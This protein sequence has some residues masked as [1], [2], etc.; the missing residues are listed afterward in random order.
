MLTADQIYN[1]FDFKL[2][3]KILFGASAAVFLFILFDQATLFLS[4]A[5]FAKKT[6]P[7]NVV[8]L[9]FLDEKTIL[10][11]YL[12]Q[13]NDPGLF[14]KKT[15]SETGVVKKQ[16]AVEALKDYRLKGVVLLDKPEAIFID[17]RDNKSMFVKE[18]DK[19]GDADVVKIGEG[20]VTLKYFEE[21]TEMV[22]K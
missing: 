10:V 14:R 2:L 1:T 15:V 5:S 17:A 16:S 11:K 13:F 19:I 8:K 6:A 12:S 4:G 9:E 18:G 22:L 21:N 7:T 20:K 3:K